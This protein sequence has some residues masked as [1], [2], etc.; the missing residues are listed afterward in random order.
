MGVIQLRMNNVDTVGN[1]VWNEYLRVPTE[2]TDL[3]K[4]Q[5]ESGDILF[6]NTNSTELVGKSA[7]FRGYSEP[8]VY[9]NHFT[10]IRVNT[11]SFSPAYIVS[12]LIW[13]YRLGTFA[14]L[15]NVGLDKVQLKMKYCLIWKSHY[16]RLLNNRESQTF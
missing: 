10:R 1:F 12:W 4:Y 16:L 14:K 13:Q 2:A 7:L 11:G 9:S 15:C 8:I 6:N 3:D 5:L